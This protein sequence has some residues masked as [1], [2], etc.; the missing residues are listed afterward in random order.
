[1]AAN[2]TGKNI[3]FNTTITIVLVGR[4]RSDTIFTSSYVTAL[5]NIHQTH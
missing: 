4:Q 3:S 2:A 5:N 1:M